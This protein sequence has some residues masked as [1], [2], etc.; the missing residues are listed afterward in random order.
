MVKIRSLRW[1]I[2]G[3]TKWRCQRYR[4]SN[5][6]TRKSIL[7]GV[8][9]TDGTD[10]NDIWKQMKLEP[11][12]G[13]ENLQNENRFDVGSNSD[14]SKSYLN[15]QFRKQNRDYEIKILKIVLQDSMS[16]Q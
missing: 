15:Y 16:E 2:L 3:I 12:V 7:D 1:L 4:V 8:D 5:K 9:V 14:S 10:G 6:K 13:K 11:M